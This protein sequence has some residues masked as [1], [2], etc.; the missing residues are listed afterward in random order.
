MT[1]QIYRFPS[2]Y[3]CACHTEYSINVVT[4]KRMIDIVQSD[5]TPLAGFEYIVA[6]GVKVQVVDTSLLVIPTELLYGSSQ[7]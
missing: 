3:C 5:L 4:M 1:Q 2:H 6:E 7:W